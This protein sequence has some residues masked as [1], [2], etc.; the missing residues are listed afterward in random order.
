MGDSPEESKIIRFVFGR[1]SK[2]VAVLG[3]F[4]FVQHDDKKVALGDV[5]FS[6]P[7]LAVG[8]QNY[9]Q[10][11][12]MPLPYLRETSPPMAPEERLTLRALAGPYATDDQT[13]PSPTP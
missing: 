6:A 3:C 1:P 5:L 9:S 12:K 4:T 2:K 7:C 8:E 11:A 10:S 13:L